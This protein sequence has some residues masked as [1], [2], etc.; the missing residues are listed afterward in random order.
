MSQ[1]KIVE[2]ILTHSV[3]GRGVD[4]DPYRR[5]TE[6]WTKD[7][8]LVAAASHKEFPQDTAVFLENAG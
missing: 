5:V 1:A 8:V 6:L 7:G 3:T 2:L 4:A